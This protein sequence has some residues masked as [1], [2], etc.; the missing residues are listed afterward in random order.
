MRLLWGASGSS[1]LRL[2]G[3]MI[4][5]AFDDLVWTTGR[6]SFIAGDRLLL[7]TDGLT[8]AK[9]D[10]GLF[11]AERLVTLVN[12][13]PLTGEALLDEILGSI[14]TFGGGRPAGDD[15]TLFTISIP[16]GSA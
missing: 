14:A 2:T 1:Q 12:A 3:P 15:L 6:A 4:S 10:E 8:E 13:S 16:E 7:Y 5:P 9:G 11:G